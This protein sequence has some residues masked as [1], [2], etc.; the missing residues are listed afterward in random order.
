MEKEIKFRGLRTDGKGQAIGSLLSPNIKDEK[1]YIIGWNGSRFEVIPET[2]GQLHNGLTRK[3]NQDVYVGDEIIYNLAEGMG[4]KTRR[5]CTG[6]VVNLEFD[7]HFYQNVIV[8][9]NTHEN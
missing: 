9:G 7:Y 3:A 5:G 6:T 8:I 1:C 2:V 4:L